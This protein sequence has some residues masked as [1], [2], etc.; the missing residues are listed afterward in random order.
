MGTPGF[1]HFESAKDVFNEL[2]E[3]SPIYH[4]LDWDRIENSEYQWPCPEK[5]HPGTPRLHEKEFK[6]GRGLFKIIGYRDPAEIIDDEFPVWLTTGRRLQSYH[7]RT[8]TGRSS[9]IDYLLNEETLE[10]HP[11]DAEAWGIRDGQ[12]V[13]MS[14]R[15][16]EMAKLTSAPS[17]RSRP[18]G[19]R[20]SMRRSSPP[21]NSPAPDTVTLPG[22]ALAK[23]IRSC[24]ELNWLSL[25]TMTT[26]GS[27]PQLAIGSNEVAEYFTPPLIA[28]A[29]KCGIL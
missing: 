18:G 9:G 6:N 13:K 19:T 20:T 17:P 26:A 10:I 3:L 14:S 7:T 1:D 27:E 12:F 23:S 4:G 22:L 15:R 25:P 2:C 8:Q 21:T 5:D 11:A 24:I 28:W 29:T 16:G